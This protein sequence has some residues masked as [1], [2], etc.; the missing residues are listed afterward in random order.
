MWCFLGV[1]RCSLNRGIGI[2]VLRDFAAIQSFLLG[3]SVKAAI[4]KR[5][6]WVLQKY[7]ENPVCS[8]PT[9]FLPVVGVLLCNH[10]SREKSE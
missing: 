3:K 7:I 9:A 1:C 8:C 10:S 4:G 5:T 6:T 2:E